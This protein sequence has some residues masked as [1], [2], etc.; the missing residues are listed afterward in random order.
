MIIADCHVH[1]EFSSDSNAPVSSIIEQA[2]ARGME[3]F[4]LTDHHDIDFPAEAQ[5]HEGVYQLVLI[6]KIGDA[7]FKNKERVVT[8][9]YNNVFELVNDSED[10][11]DSIVQLEI[12]NESE[13]E[14][15]QDVYVIAGKYNNGNIRLNKNDQ[16]VVD[17]DVSPITDWYEGD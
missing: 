6:A 17:I 12:N 4:Y 16:S 1:S 13:V 7:G 3:Y 9:N 5:L 14:P 11:T 15:L 8:V 10:A 2:I